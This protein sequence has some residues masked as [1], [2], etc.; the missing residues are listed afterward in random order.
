M[1]KTINVPRPADGEVLYDVEE[2]VFEDIRAN[3]GEQAY[4]FLHTVPYEGSVA[5]VNLLTATR[6]VRVVVDLPPPLHPSH[7]VDPVHR[8]LL[9]LTR[10]RSARPT[11]R[12]AAGGR[13][14]GSF[15]CLPGG[16][17]PRPSRC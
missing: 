11:G 4:V 16:T 12:R 8:W 1:P 15:T 2:K 13:A 14:L 3:P 7:V 5:L 10:Q 6:L 9:S 17:L